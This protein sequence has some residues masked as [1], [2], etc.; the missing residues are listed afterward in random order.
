[1]SYQVRLQP[2][3]KTFA[4]ED[5]ETV[6]DAAVRQD[7][8]L[9]F[10]CQSGGCGA[11]RARLIEG[12]INYTLPPHALAPAEIE[13]GYVLLCQA[14]PSTDLMLAA[15]ELPPGGPR[16]I[17][18]LAVRVERVEPLSHDVVALH[19]RLP[20]GRRLAFR[21]GQYVDVLLKDGRRRSFSIASPPSS[22]DTLA[23]HLRR[24]P[25]GQFTGRVFSGL[26]PRSILRIEGP[27]GSF[28]LRESG[29]PI[30]MMAGGTGFA[31]LKSMIEDAFERGLGRPLHL[32]WGA[33]A[34][35]DLYLPALPERW[36][37]N[38]ADFRY[39]PVLSDPHPRDG[40]QG[41]TGWVHEALAADHPDLRGFDVYM[42]GPPPMI[43]AA[44]TD[45]TRLGLPLDRLFYDTFD[46][47][48]ETWPER[49]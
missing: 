3:G 28:Y 9:P 33:R 10:G 49:G 48:Y 25:G 13:A 42:S 39:T 36:A 38:C 37:A 18:N 40:W 32:Y 41:R 15:E 20:R 17:R 43:D 7:I 30:L 14:Q 19:L 5:G 35:R 12:E 16:I 31:P 21:P 34:R 4:V 45:F 6:L 47:A 1:M 26:M 46:Y 24:V 23:L 44:K 8:A 22:E 27:L 2:S 11:C 29:R